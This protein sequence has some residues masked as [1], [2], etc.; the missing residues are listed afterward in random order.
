MYTQCRSK[1]FYGASYK[2]YTIDSY[3]TNRNLRMRKN[4]N[5]NFFSWC[6]MW[7]NGPW[8]PTQ[9]RNLVRSHCSPPPPLP[10]RT[11]TRYTINIQFIKNTYSLCVKNAFSMDN[12]LTIKLVHF[13]YVLC[14]VFMIYRMVRKNIMIIRIVYTQCGSN[15]LVYCYN[16]I[17]KYLC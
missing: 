8:G 15:R 2:N 4:L 1:T 12:Y 17:Y 10:L 13:E 16:L 3:I 5:N 6:K 9:V 11:G 7:L 14:N